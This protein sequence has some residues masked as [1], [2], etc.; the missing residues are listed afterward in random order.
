VDVYN[1][2]T[3][4]VSPGK[5]MCPVYRLIVHLDTLMAC[6]K[7]VMLAPPETIGQGRLQKEALVWSCQEQCDEGLEDYLAA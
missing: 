5:L 7:L 1:R 4:K 6:G 3:G 2:V